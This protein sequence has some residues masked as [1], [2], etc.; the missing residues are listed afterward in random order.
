VD[1]LEQLFLATSTG[2]CKF[3]KNEKKDILLNFTQKMAF[4]SFH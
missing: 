4:N 2:F 3:V 1:S